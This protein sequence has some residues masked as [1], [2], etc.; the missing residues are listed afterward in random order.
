MRKTKRRE[1][2]AGLRRFGV[3]CQVCGAPASHRNRLGMAVCEMK[4]YIYKKPRD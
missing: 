2:A 3:R 4:H 1:V